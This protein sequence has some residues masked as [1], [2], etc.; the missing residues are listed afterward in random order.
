[1]L[2]Q[3]GSQAITTRPHWRTMSGPRWNRPP[4]IMSKSVTRGLIECKSGVNVD[5]IMQHVLIYRLVDGAI[6]K[7]TACHVLKLLAYVL[8]TCNP[9]WMQTVTCIL[10]GCP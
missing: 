1:M 10:V 4:G 7:L 2:P 3:V 8:A 5:F 9:A 6:T